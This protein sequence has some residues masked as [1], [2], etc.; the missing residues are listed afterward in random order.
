MCAARNGV[1]FTR[2]YRSGKVEK[3]T[4][5]RN[6]LSKNKMIWKIARINSPFLPPTILIANPDI[7]LNK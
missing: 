2:R 3:P 1:L 4:I 6:L 7:P 5:V